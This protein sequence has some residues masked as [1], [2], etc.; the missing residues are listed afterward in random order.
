[1]EAMTEHSQSPG[2]TQ[3]HVCSAKMVLTQPPVAL[4]EAHSGPLDTHPSEPQF[5]ALYNGHNDSCQP[6]ALVWDPTC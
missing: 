5:A 1:M 2:Q 6:R 4:E 3:P